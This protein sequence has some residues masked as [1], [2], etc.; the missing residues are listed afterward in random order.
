MT[1]NYACIFGRVK[2]ALY[3]GADSATV[4][5]VSEHSWGPTATTVVI[6]RGSGQGSRA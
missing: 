6:P 2:L 4:G 3:D 1:L 5:A